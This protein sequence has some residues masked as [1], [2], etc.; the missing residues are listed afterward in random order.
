MSF[1]LSL[2]DNPSTRCP[3]T[4]LLDTSTSMQGAPIR[5]LQEG[6]QQFISA[7]QEDDM[8]RYSVELSI[9]TFGNGVEQIQDFTE[10][11][12]ISAPEKIQA[13]GNTPM[14]EALDKALD[15]LQSQQ[16]LY[17]A[18][19]IPAYKPW[20]VL[21][22]DGMP[23]DEWKYAAQRACDKALAGKLLFLGIGIGQVDLENFA[24]IL[25]DNC[26]P[27]RLQ[28]LKFNEFF[29]WLS[30][31]LS[32][33]SRSADGHTVQLASTDSWAQVSPF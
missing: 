32:Q 15:N 26:P 1:E 18:N 10:V 33:V 29:T 16:K 13:Y 3:V 12:N 8:A 28:G 4:L 25:P 24:Q 9:T 6:V 11:A 23:T 22:S 20:L 27:K 17:A 7:M 2:T 14:G 21:M 31:S 5:E 19:G 30:D